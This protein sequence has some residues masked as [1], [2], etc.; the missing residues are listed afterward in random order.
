MNPDI[1]I[2]K[3]TTCDYCNQ[4][5]KL[6]VFLPCH[7]TICEEDLFDLCLSTK[8]INCP[9]CKRIHKIPDK[10]FSTNNHMNDLLAINL[11][12]TKPNNGNLNAD[13]EKND[14]FSELETFKDIVK[15]PNEFI[16][17]HFLNIKKELSSRKEIA[18]KTIN[19]V[20]QAK[21]EE[22]EK[23]ELKCLNRLNDS[24]SNNHIELI[25]KRKILNDLFEQFEQLRKLANENKCDK[26]KLASENKCDKYNQMLKIINEIDLFK[27]YLLHEENYSFRGNKFEFDEDYFGS[28]PAPDIN[29]NDS[30]K[31]FHG[32]I[33]RQ[34]KMVRF[35]DILTEENSKIDSDNQIN[36]TSNGSNEKVIYLILDLNF[37]FI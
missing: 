12:N 10:G 23:N 31:S 32:K 2:K 36:Q 13:N 22:I 26:R 7:A 30:S 11:A 6:P 27:C 3:V 35:Q 9:F 33:I 8:E 25:E 20:Y 28:M 5:Y 15:K 18:V 16:L 29:N 24:E 17:D 34:T 19:E 4:T 1:I 14:E 21:L 37:I